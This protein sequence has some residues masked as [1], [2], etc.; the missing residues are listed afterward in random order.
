MQTIICKTFE[1]APGSFWFPFHP[2][3]AGPYGADSS[4]ETACIPNDLIEFVLF[5]V[6]DSL[7]LS[8]NNFVIVGLIVTYYSRKI[9][10]NSISTF[11]VAPK[12][13]PFNPE[14]PGLMEP[15]L[16]EKLLDI[17]NDLIE[18]VLFCLLC[19]LKSLR[20]L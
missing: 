20:V 8:V 3:T 19:I 15:I 6:N 17:P 4:W 16:V 2:K 5:P 18:F 7:S 12:L 13:F 11:E 14:M 1:V 10:D 9:T